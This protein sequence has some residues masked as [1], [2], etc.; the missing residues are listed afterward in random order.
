[1]PSP[2]GS[3]FNATIIETGTK[4]YRPARAKASH[5]A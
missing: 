2:T 3:P 5:D 1:M 4:P